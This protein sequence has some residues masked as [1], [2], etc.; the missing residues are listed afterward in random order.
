MH[1]TADVPQQARRIEELIAKLEVSGDP[2]VVAAAKALVEALMDLHGAAIERMLEIVARTGAAGQE[3]ADGFGRDDL[4]GSLLVLY[5]L[6]PLDL[7]ARVRRTLEKLR[8]PLAKQGGEVE[9]IGIDRG[10]VR[11]RVRAAGSNCGSSA[12]SVKA[13]VEEAILGAAPD[14]VELVIDGLEEAGSSSGFV[15]IETLMGGHS[16]V[17]LNGVKPV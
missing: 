2:V 8:P 14:A 3:I 9:L 13:A 17:I 16:T 7:E 10:V 11:L 15:P 4:V 12:G 6:H 1:D 5:G